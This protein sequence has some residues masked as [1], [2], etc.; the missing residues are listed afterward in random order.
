[1]QSYELC[2]DMIDVCVDISC[3]YGAKEEQNPLAYDEHSRS[4][5]KLNNG[6]VLYLREMTKYLA[7]VCLMREENFDKH[8]VLEFNFITLKDAI[9]KVFER[10]KSRRVKKAVAQQ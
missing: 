2:S 6:M 1:M 8:G 10:P 4:I 9:R 7:L 3:I 5:I